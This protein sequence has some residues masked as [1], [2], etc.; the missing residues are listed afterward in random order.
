MVILIQVS[1]L[2]DLLLLEGISS[3]SFLLNNFCLDDVESNT[4]HCGPP[5]PCCMIKL[6]DV[7]EMGLQVE[8]DGKG[9]VCP[10]FPSSYALVYIKWLH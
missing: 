5:I 7:P 10:F 2:Q 3:Q 8:R 6:Y 9:E 1:Q 4:G